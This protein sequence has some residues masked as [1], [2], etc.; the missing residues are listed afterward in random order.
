MDIKLLEQLKNDFSREVSLAENADVLRLLEI[1]YTGRN[2]KLTLILRSLKELP[3]DQKKIIGSK[4]NAIKLDIEEQL[5]NKTRDLQKKENALLAEKE[6][7]DVTLPNMRGIKAM[8]GH[9]HPI[10][11]AQYEIEDIFTSMG[12]MLLDG[13]ELESEY[14][15]FEALNIPSWH[16]ARD[17]QD[18][19]YIED[20]RYKIQD[21]NGNLVMRTQTSS[22]QVR[23]LQ[24]YGAPI[25]A[26]APGRVFRAEA[27]D[28]RHEHTFYQ[29]EGFMV[30]K[31]ISIAHLITVVKTFLS[32][33]L[34]KEIEA[35][36]R[37]GYFPFVEPGMEVDLKCSICGGKGCAVCKNTGW[38]E[39]MGCGIIHPNVLKAG[40]V[41]PKKYSGF[42]FGF[43]LNRL[44]MMKH[45]I[46]DIRLFMGGDLRFLE[47]F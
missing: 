38:V 26:I 20:T 47:Q 36:V 31:D 39:F 37:P 15:N 14:Y 6:W 41:D 19:F 25:K 1:A 30:D 17:M 45:G 4:A 46:D 24:A 7:I 42:A 10:T 3:E 35:R 16:P 23:A 34:G 32:G 28:A 12:F 5:K 2:G 8:E 29:V 9:L 11:Q 18:T 27:T 33:A 40:N 43:G 44:V 21:T 13:P 22:V